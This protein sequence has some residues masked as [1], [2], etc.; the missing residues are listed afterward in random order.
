MANE[1][2]KTIKHGDYAMATLYQSYALAKMHKLLDN[3]THEVSNQ[4][5]RAGFADVVSNFSTDIVP[6]AIEIRYKDKPVGWIG[7]PALE[8]SPALKTWLEKSQEKTSDDEWNSIVQRY[9]EPSW[10]SSNISTF[11]GRQGTDN[12]AQE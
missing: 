10:R 8:M 2:Q 5:R 6:G 11:T 3:L 1:F 7:F 4:S 9:A 12:E